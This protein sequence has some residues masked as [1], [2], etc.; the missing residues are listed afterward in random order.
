MQHDNITFFLLL[1]NGIPWQNFSLNIENT[2]AKWKMQNGITRMVKNNMF[3][4]FSL[5]FLKNT[6]RIEEQ[7]CNIAIRNSSR[8]NNLLLHPDRAYS[9]VG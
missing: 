3:N 9:S 6:L 7:I 8:M 5:H 2:I 1:E 4:L